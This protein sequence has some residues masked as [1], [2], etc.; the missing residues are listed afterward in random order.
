MSPRYF[1]KFTG[2]TEQNAGNWYHFSPKDY[3]LDSPEQKMHFLKVR[4]YLTI[5]KIFSR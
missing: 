4:I 3:K 2:S 1:A 5:K